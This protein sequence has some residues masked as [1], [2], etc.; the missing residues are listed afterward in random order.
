MAEGI[1]LMDRTMWK[2]RWSTC[3]LCGRI[4]PWP[5]G[6]VHE[7]VAG[8][9]AANIPACWTFLCQSCHEAVQS[10]RRFYPVLLAR[11][12]VLDPTNYDRVAVTTLRGRHKDSV[13]ED[14]VSAAAA[15]MELFKSKGA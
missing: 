9:G 4:P 15:A 6:Q 1:T 5:G 7:I 8:R 2:Q 11:K 13:T 3:W 14:E 12:R 10:Q